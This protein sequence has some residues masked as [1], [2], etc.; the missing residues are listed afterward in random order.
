MQQSPVGGSER[1]RPPSKISTSG[2]VA[3]VVTL[4]VAVLGGVAAG[5]VLVNRGD[6]AP[7]EAAPNSAGA[8]SPAQSPTG[9]AQSPGLQPTVF[10]TPGPPSTAAPPPDLAAVFGRV[11]SGVV[12]VLASTCSA[13]GIGSGFLTDARTA[14]VALGSVKQPV[15]VVV[16]VRGRS[17]PA[18]VTSVS[19]DTGLATLQLARPVAGHH[20]ALGAP[21]TVGQSVGVVGVPAAGSAPT[22]TKAAVTATDQRGSGLSGLFGLQGRADLGLSGA[23]VVDGSGAVV[24]IVVADKHETKLKAV[25]ATTLDRARSERRDEGSCGKPKG[26]QIKTVIA[27]D[28]PKESKATLQRYFAGINTGDYDAVVDAFE[29]G[30]LR[31]ARSEIER[32]FR[33]TYDFNIKIEEWQGQNVWVRFDSIFAAGRGPRSSLTCAHWSRV[34]V[35]GDSDGGTRIGRVENRPGI[36]L[37]RAC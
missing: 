19:K 29:P 36:P 10:P 4:T 1:G 18:T 24:G 23:P 32:G 26:P 34:Y 22:L 15:A 33:S 9:S 17:I 16:V 30:T 6:A 2:R 25:P 21:P 20:F 31:G 35:F 11:R 28:A 5:V 13:T 27:G 8:S 14:I 12:R 7:D 37:Y 3:A